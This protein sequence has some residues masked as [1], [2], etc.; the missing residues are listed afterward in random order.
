MKH[1]WDWRERAC[2]KIFQS[3]KGPFGSPRPPARRKFHGSFWHVHLFFTNYGL[4]PIMLLLLP[5]KGQLTSLVL[6]LAHGRF[7]DS[8]EPK[9]Q[10]NHL[11]YMHF[12]YSFGELEL[13]ELT[14][15]FL[16]PCLLWCFVSDGCGRR[17]DAILR[18]LIFFQRVCFL[19]V[20][21]GLASCD[22]RVLHSNCAVSGS[23]ITPYFPAESCKFWFQKA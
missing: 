21:S 9:F 4:A 20:R 18:R 14:T 11:H 15:L 5:Q 1:R 16:G 6:R 12:D 19:L 10:T 13:P 3:S 17:T 23:F 7:R 8:K 2:W 22:N